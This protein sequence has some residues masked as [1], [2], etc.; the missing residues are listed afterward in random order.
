MVQLGTC[1]ALHSACSLRQDAYDK[2][3]AGDAKQVSQYVDGPEWCGNSY[4]ARELS[5]KPSLLHDRR[6]V[7]YRVGI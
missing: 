3:V 4:A 6:E 5:M 1:T 7:H 2:P